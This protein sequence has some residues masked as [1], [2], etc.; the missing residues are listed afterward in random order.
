[1]GA[2]KDALYGD[3]I[4]DIDDAASD[5]ILAGI[6]ASTAA[7]EAGFDKDHACTQACFTTNWREI[8][9][10][11]E[12]I[13]TADLIAAGESLMRDTGARWE[14]VGRWWT[15]RCDSY[16]LGSVMD[17]PNDERIDAAMNE[18]MVDAIPALLA[19]YDQQNP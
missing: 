12:P 4:A 18:I 5:A 6:M 2:V 8:L 3:D 14:L 7:H 17:G 19:V 15:L 9:G 13:Q 1:M 16:D 11:P 10:E